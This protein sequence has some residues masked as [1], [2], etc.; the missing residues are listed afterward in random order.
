MDHFADNLERLL[1]LH[2]LTAR[3]AAQFIDVTPQTL[4][5]WKSQ[6]TAPG[7]QAALRVAGFFEIHA[8]RLLN[9][10]FRELLPQEI[11][12]EARFDRVEQKISLHDH[13][14]RAIESG[15]PVDITT[16]K[17][18]RPPSTKS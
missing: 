3:R 18:L 6:K 8:D 7:L 2:R 13:S 10:P 12:D 11:A 4:S 15:E 9:V 1:G 16:G 17:P 5:D 14:L